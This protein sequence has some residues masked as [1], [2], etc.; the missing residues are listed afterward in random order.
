MKTISLWEGERLTLERALA[1][2]KESLQTYGMLYRH[3]AIAFSGG[4]DSTTVATLVAA[5][6]HSGQVAA[7]ETLTVLYAD[8]RMELPPLHMTALR[9]LDELQQHGF[10]TH[11]V[12]PALDE[13]FFVYMF[14]RGVPPPKNRFR[15]CTPQ[16]KVKPMEAALAELREKHGE[17]F[18]MLTGIRI[19]ES[20]ARDQRLALACSKNGA[21]CGQGWYQMKT[22]EAVADV[23]APCLHWRVCHV[24]DWLTFHAPRAGFSTEAIAEIYGGD[25]KEEVNARTGCIQCNL[26]SKDIA[27]ST[28][29]RYP[30]WAY[31]APLK[32]LRPLYQ[33][34]LSPHYRLRKSG[35]DRNKDGTL[36]AHPMRL[37]PLTMEARRYGLSRVLAIQ[38]QVNSAARAERKPCVDLI[39]TEEHQRILALM[40]A[41]TWPEKWTGLEKRGDQLLPQVVADGIIQPLLYDEPLP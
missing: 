7:P 16:L 18:L 38:E 40:E 24:W 19:G 4:K 39:N 14:G 22:P 9:L 36:S 5:L 11:I 37:G 34:L 12:M 6:I 41:N 29:L 28:V 35:T 20:A 8:T 32:G 27:L 2:T 1:L 17:K 25:E 33:E 21:E 23:L 30:T 26:A 31:L 3:W 15:W 10:T 13:R